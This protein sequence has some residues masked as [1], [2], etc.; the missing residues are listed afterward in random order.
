[1]LSDSTALRIKEILSRVAKGESISLK[2]RIFIDAFADRDQT[3]ANW[4]KKAMRIERKVQSSCEI[5]KL[6]EA[7]DL[8]SPYQESTYHPEFTD[9]GEW[10]SG[11]PSWLSRS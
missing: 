4:V 7:L 2:E 8:D 9:L 1:M 5:D 3:V 6:L 11:A 10:F